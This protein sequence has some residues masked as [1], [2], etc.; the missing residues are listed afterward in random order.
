MALP[1]RPAPVFIQRKNEDP[2]NQG[3]IELAGQLL[4]IHRVAAGYIIGN[5]GK[6]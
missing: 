5:A 4:D 1:C 3:I 2:L 6:D